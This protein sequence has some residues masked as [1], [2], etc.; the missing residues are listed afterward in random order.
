MIV[1]IFALC[2]FYAIPYPLCVWFTM[3]CRSSS[4]FSLWIA[5]F[6]LLVGSSS[7]SSSFSSAF[8]F[9]F[10]LFPFLIILLQNSRAWTRREKRNCSNYFPK[11]RVCLL[12][13]SFCSLS[14]LM[15]IMLPF[16]SNSDPPFS[17]QQLFLLSFLSSHSTTACYPNRSVWRCCIMIDSSLLLIRCLIHPAMLA[18]SSLSLPSSHLSVVSSPSVPASLH[19]LASDGG[20]DRDHQH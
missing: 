10:L 15:M 14:M 16:S 3:I 1:M 8:H 5:V 6:F 11:Y 20:F 2:F 7:C 9:P 19:L 12:I 17:P 4:Q 13:F 18:L